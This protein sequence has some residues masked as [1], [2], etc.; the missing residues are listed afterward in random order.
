M[1]KIKGLWLAR[2]LPIYNDARAIPPADK[3]VEIMTKREETRIKKEA[4]ANLVDE[5]RRCKTLEAL[6]LRGL[7][8][9]D[10]SWADCP[11]HARRAAVIIALSLGN[12]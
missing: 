1:N 3:K 12:N 9:Q 8:A 5:A 7:L 11:P 4:S 10:R 6:I 2:R